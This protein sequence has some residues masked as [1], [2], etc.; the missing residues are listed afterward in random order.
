MTAW[1]QIVESDFR[2]PPEPSPAVLAA[3]LSLALADPDPAV[4]DGAAYSVLAAWI[5]RGVLDAQLTGLGDEAAARFGHPEVQARTF[6]PLLLAWVIA[7]RGTEAAWVDS[8]EQWYPAETDLRGHDPE[9]GW[10]HAVAHGADL[11][12]VL[13]ETAPARMLAVAS[14]RLLARTD[15]IWRDQ[16]DDRLAQAIALTLTRPGLTAGEAVGWLAPV[17]ADWRSAKPGPPLPY[18]SN[19]MRTLR[20]LYVLVDRGVRTDR[21]STPVD[22]PH[23]PAVL[24]TIAEILEI[25]AVH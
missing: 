18:A 16:E 3:E 24:D 11:L 8:F 25:V 4:R 2:V 10:L 20:A 9:L 17:A 5:G 23:R 6:A 19:A 14:R 7:R 1:Q 22:V 12:G 15:Y 21:E 13:G